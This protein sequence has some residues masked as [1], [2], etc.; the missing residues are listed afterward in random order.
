MIF[1][2]ARLILFHKMYLRIEI[3]ICS[4]NKC[5]KRLSDRKTLWAINSNVI[6]LSWEFLMIRITFSI[7]LSITGC[8]EVETVPES[9]AMNSKIN[10]RI[11]LQLFELLRRGIK[12]LIKILVGL[13][14]RIL[15]G[16][17]FIKSSF[18]FFEM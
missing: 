16:E 9:S 5:T 2:T 6:F 12:S 18:N 8:N 4:L 10:S 3:P 14:G 17:D 15:N 11:A 7:L 13:P 1:L